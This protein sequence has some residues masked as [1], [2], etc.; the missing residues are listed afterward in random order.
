MDFNGDILIKILSGLLLFLLGFY[1][2]Q[3]KKQKPPKQESIWKPPVENIGWLPPAPPPLIQ[4][5]LPPTP[6]SFPR[7]KPDLLLDDL[8]R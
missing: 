4:P 5:P 2:G 1:L 3:R 7:K 6:S 8:Y